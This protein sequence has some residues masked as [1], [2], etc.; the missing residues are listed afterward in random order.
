MVK[1]V[2]GFW[3]KIASW[4]TNH[5]WLKIIALALAVIIWF[6]VREELSRFSY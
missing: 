4:F 6:Y 2:F 1:A 3:R 5:P